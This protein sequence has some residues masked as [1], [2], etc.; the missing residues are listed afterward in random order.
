MSITAEKKLEI[1]ELAKQAHDKT[2]FFNEV[3]FKKDVYNIFIIKKMVTRFLR[4][5]NINEKLVLNNIIIALNT[6]DIERTNQILRMA[7]KDDEFSVVKS[8]LLFLDAHTLRDDDVE[9]HEII[10]SILLDVAKR[11]NVRY[12]YESV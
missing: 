6:F 3:E 7:M 12:R 1:V 2:G 10:N 8:F 11:H 4:S 5:G 9:P